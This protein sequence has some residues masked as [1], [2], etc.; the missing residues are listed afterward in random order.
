VSSVF[1]STFSTSFK[2]TQFAA[3]AAHRGMARII[4]RI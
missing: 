2:L 4:G 3:F 1:L